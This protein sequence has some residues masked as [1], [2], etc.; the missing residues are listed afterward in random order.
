MRQ[1][2]ILVLLIFVQTCTVYTFER[3]YRETP[4]V[5]EV[6]DREENTAVAFVFLAEKDLEYSTKGFIP[7][8]K[9]TV[10]GGFLG[11]FPFPLDFRWART[12][13]ISEKWGDP[14]DGTFDR[15]FADR[16]NRELNSETI[17]PQGRPTMKDLL[18]ATR[19]AGKKYT[20]VVVYNHYKE[21]TYE[22]G[23]IGQLDRNKSNPNSMDM[24]IYS[25]GHVKGF[26]PMMSRMLVSADGA[27]VLVH[28][29]RLSETYYMLLLSN[30]WDQGFK[31]AGPQYE[32]IKA[33]LGKVAASDKLEAMD[34]AA[35]YLMQTDFV[36]GDGSY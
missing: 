24:P 7:L 6:I 15:E 21:I 20:Y 27:S 1:C 8:A 5:Q 13:A 32:G 18:N 14:I 3:T 19:N 31:I 34:R 10:L 29:Q 25:W 30:G 16:I 17:V 23:I 2:L 28:K 12:P 11:T 36:G 4:M 35:E 26:I 33:Y 22:A 9:A